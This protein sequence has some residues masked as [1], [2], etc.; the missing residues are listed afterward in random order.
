MLSDLGAI[1][2]LA[3]REIEAR[4]VAPIIEAFGKEFGREKAVKLASETIKSLARE[5]GAELARRL[6]GNSLLDFARGMDAWKAGGALE[7]EVIEQTDTRF[8]FNMT[9][10]R[11]AEMYK[12]LGI[13]D[14]GVVLSC[15]RDFELIKGFNPELKLLRTQ[16]IMQGAKFCDFRFVSEHADE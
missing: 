15:D 7:M 12:E 10:C 11:Y 14:L 6:G 1:H 8:S 9:R 13:E 5:Q 16:T 2:I 4:I 3:R